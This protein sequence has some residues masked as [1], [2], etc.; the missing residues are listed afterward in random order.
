MAIVI[1]KDSDQFAATEAFVQLSLLYPTSHLNYK[2]AILV[3]CSNENQL[4]SQN[5]IEGEYFPYETQYDSMKELE[6]IQKQ[7]QRNQQGSVIHDQI[8][9]SLLQLR[10]LQ[11]IYGIQQNKAQTCLNIQ[12]EKQR[13]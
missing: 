11:M 4:R 6:Y 5:Q 12:N 3:I 1:S 8:I 9:A 7:L 2:L 10:S 13:T